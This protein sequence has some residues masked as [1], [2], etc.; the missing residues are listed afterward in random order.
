VSEWPAGVQRVVDAAA[1]GGLELKI[2]EYPDG[3]RTAP[4][5]AAAVGCEVGQIVK[6]LI[7]SVNGEL[8]LALTSGKNRVDTDALAVAAG[9]GRCE[10]ADVDLVRETTG[11]AIGGVAPF[12]HLNAIRSFFDPDLLAY[13]TV[14][15]A[16]GTP[17]HV[18]PI[19]PARLLTLTAATKTPFTTP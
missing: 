2:L 16:A 7:F 15:A 14:W 12:G 17:R 6:S 10:R 13:D 11:F 3:T 8:V 9:G 4:D 19:D 5:A 18:F 1:V